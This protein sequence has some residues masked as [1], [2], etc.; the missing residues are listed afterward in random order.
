MAQE[1][2]AY[3]IIRRLHGS[4]PEGV[5]RKT[6][7]QIGYFDDDTFNLG[8]SHVIRMRG[9]GP[10]RFAVV[11]NVSCG[12]DCMETWTTMKDAGCFG[13]ETWF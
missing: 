6:R 2:G 8:N 5:N 10:D 3:G 7:L 12:H 11:G 13:K 4:V 1:S 9:H